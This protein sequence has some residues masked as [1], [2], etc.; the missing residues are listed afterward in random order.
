[1]VTKYVKHKPTGKIYEILSCNTH[2]IGTLQCL[3][4][5]EI[6]KEQDIHY[7]G[8]PEIQ[9]TKRYVYVEYP[10]AS[11]SEYYSVF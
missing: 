9:R 2:G 6:C 8:Q 7:G 11:E 10:E 3:E 4:T 5:G 1:M